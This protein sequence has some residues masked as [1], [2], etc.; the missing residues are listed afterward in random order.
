M[1]M[2]MQVSEILDELKI[3]ERNKL[4]K[5]VKYLGIAMYSQTSSLRKTAKVLSE[6]HPVSKTAVW[7]W[8]RKVEEKLPNSAEKKQRITVLIDETVVKGNGLNYYIY[9]AV[10]KE[11]NEII[12]MRVYTSRNYLTSK[13]FIKGT[14]ALCENIPKFIVDR[15][16]WLKSA[17]EGLNLEY[18]H[19]TFRPEKLG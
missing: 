17:L 6:I 2:R 4:P 18:E 9:S 8:I 7:R 14:L 15:G 11:R 5:E 16:P 1:G 10:D 12:L 19:E 13:S 3:F